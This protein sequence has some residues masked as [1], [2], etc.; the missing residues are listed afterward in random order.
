MN[1][2]VW[3]AEIQVAFMLLTRL[4]A[5]H[6]SAHVPSLAAA[7]WAFPV[8]GAVIGAITA[9]AYLVF[10]SAGIP[11]VLSAIL[12]FG[13]T[14]LATG[15]LHEDG[16]ADSADGLGGG[17]DKDKKLEIM[18]DSRIGSYGVLALGLVM[19]ARIGSLAE[20]EASFHLIWSMASIGMISRLIMVLYL[21]FLPAARSTGLGKDASNPDSARL[22]IAIA[23]TLPALVYSFIFLP[24]LLVVVAIVAGG[25][26]WLAWR[27]IG[28]QTG[29]ICGAGQVLSETASL[30]ILASI[31][32]GR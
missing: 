5:G 4:P 13:V 27:Q 7:R 2:P 1:R 15:A 6:L 14:I 31:M 30:I 25:F 9:S 29:D 32:A 11:F 24:I 10:T 20:I 28:G 18:K 3:I 19:A 17:L 21:D 26:G 12:A 23:L 16:L 8:V 22:L